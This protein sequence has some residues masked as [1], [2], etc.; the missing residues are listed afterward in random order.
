M[1]LF[2]EHECELFL[3]REKG[4]SLRK[5]DFTGSKFSFLLQLQKSAVG[6]FFV[7]LFV[8]VT[9]SAAVVNIVFFKY[10]L[11][12]SQEWLY[13]VFSGKKS[14]CSLIHFTATSKTTVNYRMEE[15]RSSSQ[16]RSY[17]SRQ[18]PIHP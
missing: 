6:F 2:G 4:R 13:P 10:P 17:C 11:A 16:Q 9:T 5:K 7:F 3:S 8:S 12:K 15:G 1:C 14:I 18:T